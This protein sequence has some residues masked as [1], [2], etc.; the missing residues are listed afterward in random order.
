M[1]I[2]SSCWTKENK[3]SSESTTFIHSSGY[4]TKHH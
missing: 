4:T 2:I 3:C 1:R